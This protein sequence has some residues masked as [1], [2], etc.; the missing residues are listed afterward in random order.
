MNWCLARQLTHGDELKTAAELTCQASENFYHLFS[1]SPQKLNSAITA[2]FNL[3]QSELY[4]TWVYR[5]EGAVMGCYSAYP[6]HELNER[7]TTS[8][9]SLMDYFPLDSALMDKLRSYRTKVMPIH[10]G[11][12]Y[13]ARIAT[14]ADQQSK[15]IG[16]ELLKHFEDTAKKSSTPSPLVLHVDNE[17][18]RAIQFYLKNGFKL[19][20]NSDP[21]SISAYQ[22]NI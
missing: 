6:T 22:K 3:E 12:F 19:M 16:A 14:R 8:L 2:Q 15:G 5:K 18:L 13:L 17:N 21:Y 9:K 1:S 20:D 4:D 7:Q 11:G 10:V